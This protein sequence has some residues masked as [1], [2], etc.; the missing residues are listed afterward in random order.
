M[1]TLFALIAVSLFTVAS[2][3]WTP[4]MNITGPQNEFDPAWCSA[5]G[6][7]ATVTFGFHL[8]SQAASAASLTYT[9]TG[10][11]FVSGPT[12]V[13][14]GIKPDGD[15]SFTGGKGAA[16]TYD[17]S[18]VYTFPGTGTFTVTVCAR[19][20]GNDHDNACSS[21]TVVLACTAQ[22]DNKCD[23][24]TDVTGKVGNGSALSCK[25]TINFTFKGPYGKTT[26]VT[27]QSD[28]MRL[29]D[30]NSYF[31]LPVAR[32]GNSCEYNL[33]WKPADTIGAG[34]TVGS[35]TYYFIVGEKSYPAYLDCP[36]PKK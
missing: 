12:Y 15:W 28:A 5:D 36:S 18:F 10:G 32:N 30:G 24:Q 6:Q 4:D 26:P 27:V 19:Q 20:P 23:K 1:K 35:G 13:A 29:A 7:T 16:K 34:G 8:S 25:S 2:A 31:T 22:T 33:Q 14:D 3:D 9:Q 21:G 11:T 17:S